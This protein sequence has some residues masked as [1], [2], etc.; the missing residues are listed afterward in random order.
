MV[1]ITTAQAASVIGANLRPL[2]SKAVSSCVGTS[3]QSGVCLTETDC[4]NNSGTQDGMCENFDSCCTFQRSCGQESSFNN[5]VFTNPSYPDSDSTISQCS[6]TVRALNPDICQVRID[7]EEFELAQPSIEGSCNADFMKISGSSSEVPVLCG[8]NTGQHVYFDVDPANFYVQLNFD[9][10]AG[11]QVANRT[12]RVNIAQFACDSLDKAPTGCLQYHRE[13]TGEV[14]S[15]N[16]QPLLGEDQPI[17]TRQLSGL[18]YDICLASHS[19]YCSVI[20]M[21]PEHEGNYHFMLT[22]DSNSVGPVPSTPGPAGV[23]AL[24]CQRDYV[25]IPASDVTLRNGS[26]ISADRFCGL[27]FPL[28]ARSSVQPFSL[29]AVTDDKELPDDY[30]N[31]GFSLAYRLNACTAENGETDDDSET[32]GVADSEVDSVADSKT[33]GVEDSE[34]DGVKGSDTDVVADSEADGVVDSKT[35][36]VEDSDTDVVAD[37]VTDGVD[38]SDADGVNN[39]ET[40]GVDDSETDGVADDEKENDKASDDQEDCDNCHEQEDKAESNDR[41]QGKH[42]DKRDQLVFR[43]DDNVREVIDG[44]YEEKKQ[45]KQKGKK[46]DDSDSGDESSDEE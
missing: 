6:L 30:S 12:W 39:S 21:Q 8:Y 44:S 23:G 10:L 28:S 25:I 14:S 9:L 26:V 2:N 32:D 33:D 11:Q 13:T 16:Y 36:G 24:L 45:K 38:N 46:N 35:D 41:K 37:S 5:T 34:T 29:Y 3:G 4:T 40:D 22:G 7:F 31:T 20:W 17:A 15:F 42:H 18:S 27:S 19:G 43:R 1:V